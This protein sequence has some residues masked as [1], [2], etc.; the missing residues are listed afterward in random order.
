M[1]QGGWVRQ[2]PYRPRFSNWASTVSEW[3]PGGRSERG[4]RRGV[5]RSVAD[6][7]TG[8][9]APTRRGT[10]FLLLLHPLELTFR[11]GR[12]PPRGLMGAPAAAR[13]AGCPTDS[14]TMSV[15]LP[16]AARRPHDA[17]LRAAGGRLGAAGPSSRQALATRGGPAAATRPTD[18]HRLAAIAALPGSSAVAPAQAR[19]AGHRSRPSSHAPRPG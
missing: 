8:G 16:S 9:P 18:G 3:G 15:V 2:R 6:A 5:E 14:A 11:G 4:G 1:T 13:R 10:T 19:S 12:A 7:G 17:S